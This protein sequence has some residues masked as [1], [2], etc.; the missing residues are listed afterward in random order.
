MGVNG[1]HYA[2]GEEVEVSES[3]GF[4]LCAGKKAELVEEVEPEAE[5]EKPAGKKKA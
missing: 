4:Y 1:V 5:T 3:D 2:A